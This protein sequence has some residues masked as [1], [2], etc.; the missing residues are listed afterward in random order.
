MVR[1]IFLFDG[2]PFIISIM[3][4]YNLVFVFTYS[5]PRLVS[6][7]P[8]HCLV[9]ILLCCRRRRRRRRRRR[10]CLDGVE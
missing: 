8:H 1:V 4:C 5:S 10:V 9:S 3:L 7:K 2:I 6:V